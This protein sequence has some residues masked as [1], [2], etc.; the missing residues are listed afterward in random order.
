LKINLKKFFF[1]DQS[2]ATLQRRLQ[3][4]QKCCPVDKQGS[5]SYG[6][7]RKMEITLKQFKGLENKIKA[8]KS[9]CTY[10]PITPLSSQ[11]GK[12]RIFLKEIIQ[13]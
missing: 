2:L 6:V 7:E 4:L 5:V 3:I 12:H 11:I 8:G 9:W 13:L 10:L 1:T